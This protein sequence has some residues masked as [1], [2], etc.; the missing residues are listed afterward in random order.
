MNITPSA[1]L[2]ST[3]PVIDDGDTCSN[4]E[5]AA[6][7]QALANYCK[8]LESLTI[9]VQQVPMTP[10]Y[11]GAG[12]MLGQLFPGPTFILAQQATTDYALLQIVGAGGLKVTGFSFTGK[13][14]GVH[15]AL[16]ANKASVQLV[17]VR[18]GIST[19]TLATLVDS[20]VSVGAYEAIHTESTT[21]L[22]LVLDRS[23]IYALQLKA[24]NGANSLAS[25]YV[26][27]GAT[28][29]LAEP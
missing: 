29:T 11:N 9:G 10:M 14:D 23:K 24:E 18:P 15:G 21:G 17:E 27:L 8:Y 12:G 4:A 3:I 25:G 6:T 13:G 5:H 26:W 28:V 1:T 20:S 2:P 16:P 7:A 22:S 19:L